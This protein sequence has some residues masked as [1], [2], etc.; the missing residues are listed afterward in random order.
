V[1]TVGGLV[2]VLAVF[3][4]CKA[5]QLLHPCALQQA[6]YVLVKVVLLI[7]SLVAVAHC[8]DT[9][10]FGTEHGRNFLNTYKKAV[11]LFHWCS[12]FCLRPAF[13]VAKLTFSLCLQLLDGRQYLLKVHQISDLPKA[14]PLTAGVSCQYACHQAKALLS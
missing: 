10:A 13:E 6:E 4:P 1:A 9:T 14:Q 7:S 8:H 3:A 12:K 5:A 11:L 2:W